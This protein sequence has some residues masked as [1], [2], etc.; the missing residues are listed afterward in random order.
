MQ[1]IFRQLKSNYPKK[2]VDSVRK[3]EKTHTKITLTRNAIEFLT[4]CKEGGLNPNF[5]KGVPENLSK[6]MLQKEIDKK[7]SLI[8]NLGNVSSK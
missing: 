4:K 5:L 7:I 1:G 6:Q 2:T 8:N 3:W